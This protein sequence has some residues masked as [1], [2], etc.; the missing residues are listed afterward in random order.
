MRKPVDLEGGVLSVFELDGF[1]VLFE[2]GL[3]E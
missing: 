1:D 2:G 3:D